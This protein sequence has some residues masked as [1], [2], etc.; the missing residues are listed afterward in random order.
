MCCCARF[1]GR[2][3]DHV[4][5]LHNLLLGHTL[6]RLVEALESGVDQVDEIV[7][8]IAVLKAAGDTVIVHLG[9]E[10]LELG[11]S[12]KSITISI[13]AVKRLVNLLLELDAFLVAVAHRVGVGVARSLFLR[14]E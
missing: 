3:I 2:L 6:R 5:N 8:C 13:A 9:N 7:R 11:L 10:C 1:F 4:Q 12:E 14:C